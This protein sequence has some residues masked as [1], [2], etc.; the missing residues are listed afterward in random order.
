MKERKDNVLPVETNGS[1]VRTSPLVRH[2]RRKELAMDIDTQQARQQAHAL[3]DFLPPDQLSAV[4]E[5]L[6]TM[7]DPVQRA[8]ALAPLE[9]EVITEEEEL[10]VAEAREWRKNNKPIPME[11][12]LADFGLT[13]ADFEKMAGEPTPARLNQ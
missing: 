12:V 3:L 1:Q 11:D 10:A 8:L 6:A 4:R 7:V 5:L 9:D 2:R 13:A